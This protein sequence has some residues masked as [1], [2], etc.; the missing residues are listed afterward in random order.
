MRLRV[1]SSIDSLTAEEY[2]KLLSEPKKRKFNNTPVVID[3]KRFDST[4]EENY[5]SEL[6][7]KKQHGLIY[8]FETQVKFIL[9]EGRKGKL[10]TYREKSYIADFV[11]YDKNKNIVSIIDVKPTQKKGSKSRLT[12]TAKYGTSIHLLYIKYGIE[13]TEV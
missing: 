8:D 10:R 9:I 3:G 7:L 6:L 5:Y 11:I 4:K 13:V 2:R 1:D 12:R